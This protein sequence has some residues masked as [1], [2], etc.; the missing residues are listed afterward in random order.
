MQLYIYNKYFVLLFWTTERGGTL[1]KIII[2]F[3]KNLF[4]LTVS[5]SST[6]WW[7][8]LLSL[9]LHTRAESQKT[10]SL[11]RI[12]FRPTGKQTDLQ[13]NMRRNCKHIQYISTDEGKLESTAYLRD[14]FGGVF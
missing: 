11:F 3:S 7:F 6:S 13:G 8:Q 2:V 14:F 10:V 12:N 9:W 4:I 5:I 1:Q